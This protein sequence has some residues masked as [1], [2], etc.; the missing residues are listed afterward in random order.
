MVLYGWG[1]D[2]PSGQGYG[3]ELWHSSKI[4]D[5]GNNNYALIDDPKIDKG[6]E[7]AIAEL[8]PD[9]AAEKYARSTRRSWRAVTTCR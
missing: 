2:F 3:I 6:L 9:K 1:P 5:N 8:D 4:R 7:D